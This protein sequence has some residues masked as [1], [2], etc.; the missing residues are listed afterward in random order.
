ML[1]ENKLLQGGN[2]VSSFF[3]AYH[4]FVTQKSGPFDNIKYN[5][6]ILHY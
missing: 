4:I 1:L 6:P 2:A 3:F 5:D